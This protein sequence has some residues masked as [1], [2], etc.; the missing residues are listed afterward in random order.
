MA[1]PRSQ[2][3]AASAQLLSALLAERELTP[4]TQLLAHHISGLLDGAAVIVY[5]VDEEAQAWI[6]KSVVGEVHLDD[7]VIPLAAGTLGAVA[8][9]RAPLLFSG[10]ELIREDYAHL[11]AR[12]SLISLAYVPIAIEDTLLGCV[13]VA[14]FDHPI[15][16]AD[17]ESVLQICEHAGAALSSA[18]Q[19][20]AERNSQLESIA[21]LTQLYDLEKVFSS[22]LE[23]DELVPLITSKIREVLEVQAV[24]L[25]M[26]KDADELLLLNRSGEDATVPVNSTQRS[27]YGFIADVSDTGEP[28]LIDDSEDERLLARNES[29]GEQPVF[30]VIACPLVHQES[31]VGVI[32]AVNKLNG[33][34]FHE[35]DL[36]LLNSIAETAAIALNNAG[37][38]QAE[39]KV[40]ILETLVTVSKEITSTLN[41]DG[42]LHTVVNGTRAVVPYDRAAVALDRRGQ[43]QVKAVSG[44]DQ[45]RL[46]D[47]EV[48]RLRDLLEWATVSNQELHIRQHEDEIDS[49][50]EETKA[51]FKEYFAETGMRAFYAIPLIDDQGRVGVLS[52]ESQDP[53]FLTEAHLEMIRVLAAQVTVALRNA[54]LYREVPF[55]GVLEPIL[56]RKK[57]FMALQKRRRAMIIAGSALAVVFLAAFPFPMRLAGDATVAPQATALIQPQLEGVVRAVQVHEGDFVKQG[58]VLG[59][60]EDWNYRSAL[61]SAQTKFETAQAEMNRALASNDGTEAGVQRMQAEFWA[62]EV[63]R[64]TERLER[65]KLRSPIDGV[66]A[67]PHLESLVGR[68]LDKGDL[69]A[70]VIDTSRITVDVAID[71]EEVSLLHPGAHAYLKLESFPAYTFR[72]DVIVVS[73]KSEPVGDERVFFARVSVPNSEGRLRAGMQGRGKISAGWRPVGYVI[74]RRPAMWLWSKLWS[75]FGW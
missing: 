34:P 41:L 31:Q 59:E 48:L 67:T 47:A 55:I 13:E 20:E 40:E 68:H 50:R 19:Y 4:R 73:T 42:V 66:V 23:M 29:A 45:L 3:V 25:W 56:Q 69:F 12:R 10:K 14:S 58:T 71:Q 1:A 38:L 39:R 62:S 44:L 70:E 30:S 43:I 28:L 22:T 11:H 65:T 8:R 17:L 36:F 60:L 27:G 18:I 35:D 6:A 51:K 46:G 57:K 61:Q 75:W 5:V 26:V 33:Q 54:E 52:F 63:K 64:A 7:D 16:S 32:E 53:D 74:L 9:D 37:L 24:N 72:G 21:R 15:S 2:S 49:D